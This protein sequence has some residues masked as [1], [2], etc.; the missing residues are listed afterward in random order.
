MADGSA[1]GP[2]AT[3]LRNVAVAAVAL[4]V[5]LSVVFALA[6]ACGTPSELLRPPVAVG[7]TT[8]SPGLSYQDPLTSQRS[9]F[10]ITF[11]QW[12]GTNA[13]PP[14]TPQFIDLVV[15]AREEQLVSGG[16]AGGV[17]L[18]AASYTITGQREQMVDFAGPYLQTQQGVLVM[19]SEERVL[20]NPSELDGRSVCA[21]RGST[22]VAELRQIRGVIVREEV[23]LLQCVTALRAGQV[24]AVSTDELLLRGYA[25]TD[26]ALRIESGVAF[27]SLQQYGIGLP[28]QDGTTDCE[29]MNRYLA[30]F[31]A[32]GAWDAAFT[33]NFGPDLDRDRFRPNPRACVADPEP[34]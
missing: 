34:G 24:D 23:G 29:L 2:P 26:P 12:L 17:D 21:Q 16:D 31:M 8:D 4:V 32:S 15:G 1:A 18:V 33:N 14:F 22:S 30:Q 9:G 28:P 7:V 10:D 6:G 11:A 25:R 3:A 20:T 13:D 5:V 27:G 19:A